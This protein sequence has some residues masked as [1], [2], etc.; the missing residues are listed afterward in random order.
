MDC[1]G[2]RRALSTSSSADNYWNPD[3][4]GSC[5]LILPIG[6]GLLTPPNVS[7][8]SSHRVLKTPENPISLKF[9]I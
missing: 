7:P 3:A 8:L 4:M 5:P 2:G 1:A 9:A 6:A